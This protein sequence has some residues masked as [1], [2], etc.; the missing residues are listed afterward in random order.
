[1]GSGSSRRGPAEAA[2]RARGGE[3]PTIRR[4]SSDPSGLGAGAPAAPPFP[5]AGDRIDTYALEASIGVGG[6]GAVFRANDLRLDRLVALKL[7]P[8]ELSND[9]EAV[10]R[11]YQEARSAA[12]L[13]HENIA[14]V[15]TIGHD[16]DYHY[17]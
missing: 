14:R 12:R 13:D 17:I 1:R 6:M 2:V 3:A 9:S 8:P 5:V 7:L 11:F 10:Q 16:R 4:G 15:Y